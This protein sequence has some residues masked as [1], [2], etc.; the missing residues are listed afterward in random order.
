MLISS[1]V[2]LHPAL[3]Q[4][5]VTLFFDAAIAMLISSEVSF[6]L[7]LIFTLPPALRMLIISLVNFINNNFKIRHF[8]FIRVRSLTN[9]C[10]EMKIRIG[11]SFDKETNEV[12][13]Q[14]QFK[15]DGERTYNAYSYD[16]FKEE[17]DAKEALNKHLNGEREYT[18]FVSI[19]KV[20][21]TI[22]G[23]RVDVKKVLAF[24]VMSAK[25]DLPGS[26]IW[27]KIN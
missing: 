19:E 20:K 15:L 9:K 18:Y 21:R 24:H 11:K 5:R 27:V 22:K 12:F 23:N 4:M 2:N 16:V 6:D 26:R 17:S 10:I 14:L 1:D 8:I 3:V 13:Y 25:S 7:Q